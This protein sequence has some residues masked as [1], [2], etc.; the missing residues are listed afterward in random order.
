MNDRALALVLVGLASCASPAPS[1]ADF[2]QEV[3]TQIDARRFDEALASLGARLQRD[4]DDYLALC[5]RAEVEVKLVLYDEAALDLQ[6]A[7][8]VEPRGADA[9]RAWSRYELGY[10]VLNFVG[11]AERALE[12]FDAALAIDPRHYKALEHRA[13]AWAAMG[14]QERAVQDFQRAIQCWPAGFDLDDLLLCSRRCAAS[15]RVL[16]RLEEAAA[17]DGRADA[18]AGAGP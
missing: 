17:M 7:I 9:L 16:G 4:L 18:Q 12:H 13:H 1:R 3:R 10:L 15:L 8:A 5:L 11:S 6:H 2:E 14:E